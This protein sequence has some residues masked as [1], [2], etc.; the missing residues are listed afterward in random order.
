MDEGSSRLSA[1][2]ASY[3]HLGRFEKPGVCALV[4]SESASTQMTLQ[5]LERY[6]R[7]RSMEAILQLA[8]KCEPNEIVIGDISDSNTFPPFRI[9]KEQL[10]R[11]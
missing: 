6:R 5:E 2:F 1:L 8:Q 9:R 4:F 10:L 11:G 3:K 7:E